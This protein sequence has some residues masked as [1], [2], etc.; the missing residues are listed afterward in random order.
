M[1]GHPFFPGT[2]HFGEFGPCWS[3]CSSSPPTFRDLENR[4]RTPVEWRDMRPTPA[5][6]RRRQ[7]FCRVSIYLGNECQ[8]PCPQGASPC[9]RSLGA[10]R[11][12]G[13]Q[14]RGGSQSLLLQTVS[15]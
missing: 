9:E 11:P 7:A 8:C 3:D 2:L 6:P 1:K 15:S 10:S 14:G 4:H 12:W 5:P 13:R